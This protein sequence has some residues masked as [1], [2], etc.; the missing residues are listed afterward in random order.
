MSNKILTVALSFQHQGHDF[1]KKLQNV[2]LN[3]EFYE[4]GERT[5]SR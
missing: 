2:M 4:S 5:R 3:C 1:L